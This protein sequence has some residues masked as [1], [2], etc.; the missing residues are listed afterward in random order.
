MMVTTNWEVAVAIRTGK[1]SKKAKIGT[2]RLPPP[3]PRKLA[4]NPKKKK[5]ANPS[6]RLYWYSNVIPSIFL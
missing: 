6:R 3:I 1:L 5:T 4:T 2:T